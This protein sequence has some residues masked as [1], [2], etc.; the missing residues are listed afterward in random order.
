MSIE[1]GGAAFPCIEASQNVA[2]GETTV[3]QWSANGITVRDY[4][5][6]KAMAAMIGTAAAPC[7]GGLDR[8]EGLCANAAYKMADAM[9]KAREVKP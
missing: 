6:A 7:L 9:L 3:H 1:D 8:A 5:A 4:F 2:T